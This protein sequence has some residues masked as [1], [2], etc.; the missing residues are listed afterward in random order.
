MEKNNQ[1]DSLSKKVQN[2][3]YTKEKKC[4]LFHNN[5]FLVTLSTQSPIRNGTCHFECN[6][7]SESNQFSDIYQYR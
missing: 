6:S 2:L 1:S 3:S 5:R 7:M 4:F